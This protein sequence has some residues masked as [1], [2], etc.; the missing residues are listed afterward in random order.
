MTAT[1]TTRDAHKLSG[2]LGAEI[3]GLDLTADLDREAVAWITA[4]LHEHKVLG[5]RGQHLDDA[6]QIRFASHLGELT[7]AHPPCRPSKASRTCCP[8]TAPTGDGPTTGTPT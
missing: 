4:A 6:G 8:S 5:F 3:V 1:T 7:A 2:R